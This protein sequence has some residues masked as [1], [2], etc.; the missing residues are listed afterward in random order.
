M[1]DPNDY[2][3]AWQVY[4]AVGL[5]AILLWVALLWGVKG[6]FLRLWLILAA[7]AFLFMPVKHPDDVTL[8]VP[9]SVGSI[10]SWMT[11]GLDS[12]M[13]AWVALA[14]GQVLA[15]LLALLAWMALNRSKKQGSATTTPERREPELDSGKG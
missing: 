6:L 12:A 11:A 2:Q 4:L 10:L 1:I 5:L 15:L 3:F 8:W 9:A 14:G 13:P 7:A